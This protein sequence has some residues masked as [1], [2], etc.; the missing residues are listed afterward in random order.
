MKK[1]TTVEW[2]VEEIKMQQ[3]MQQQI[4]LEKNK[5]LKIVRR[6]EID[7]YIPLIE[8]L[9]QAKEL[10]SYIAKIEARKYYLKGF[11]DSELTEKQD[12]S[13]EQTMRDAETHFELVYPIKSE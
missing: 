11:K 12:V 7:K 6:K 8:L 1:M 9:D 10:E 4:D 5:L 13:H 3:Q 2:L